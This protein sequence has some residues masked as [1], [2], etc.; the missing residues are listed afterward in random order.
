MLFASDQML[1]STAEP[2]SEISDSFSLFS[3]CDLFSVLEKKMTKSL[4]LL[5]KI[6]DFFG[7]IELQ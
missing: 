1:I 3:F 2:S 4:K 5:T 7:N 6:V